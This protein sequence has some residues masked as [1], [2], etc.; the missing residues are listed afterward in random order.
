MEKCISCGVFNKKYCFIILF[1]VL[2]NTI[3]VIIS[4]L[5]LISS[6]LLNVEETNKGIFLKPL[7]AYIGQ[8]LCI[9]PELLVKKSLTEE[10]EKN[11]FDKYK[12]KTLINELIFNDLSDRLTLRDK[13]NI[14]IISLI[15]LIVDYIKLYLSVANKNFDEDYNFIELI[16]LFLISLYFYDIKFYNH[17]YVSLAFFIIIQL[18]KIIIKYIFYYSNFI[19]MITELSFQ[20]ILGL[21]EAIIFTY[22]K[23]LMEIKFFSPYKATY[24]FGFINGIITLILLIIISFFSIGSLGLVEYKDSYYFDSYY[25][26]YDNFNA[27]QIILSI[28]SSFFLGISRLI[29]NA[30]INYFTVCHLFLLFPVIELSKNIKQ[31]IIN[32]VGIAPL[33]IINICEVLEFIFFLVFLEIIELNCFGLNKYTKKNIKKRAGE[34]INL[35]LLNENMRTD[36]EILENNSIV[37]N[38]GIVS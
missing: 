15:L 17:Q 34:D 3:A 26:I 14:F 13:I 12:K 29:F 7:L 33:L 10:K 37:V 18:I 38:N 23:Y 31:E 36:T 8:S 6:F 32:K 9:I 21:F 5:Y 1:N 11:N 25:F 27:G 19:E 20:I 4:F 24:I 16:F 30:T 22:S 28:F 2:N 35:L